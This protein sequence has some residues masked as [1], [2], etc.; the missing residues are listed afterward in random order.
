MDG[1]VLLVVGQ[2]KT[3]DVSGERAEAALEGHGDIGASELTV[4]NDVVDLEVGVEIGVAARR[5]LVSQR[6]SVL[7]APRHWGLQ[8]PSP[9]SFD[10]V[11]KLRAQ[12]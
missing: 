2:T 8:Y 4:H 12:R 5:K 10:K 1:H 11:R 3:I 6:P 9:R 7:R